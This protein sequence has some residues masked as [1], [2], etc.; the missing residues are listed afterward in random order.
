METYTFLDWDGTLLESDE[1]APEEALGRSARAGAGASDDSR[2]RTQDESNVRFLE[3]I[4]SLSREVSIVTLARR[5]WVEVSARRWLPRT[6]DFLAAHAI[7][8][9]YAVELEAPLDAQMASTGETQALPTLL[10]RRAMEQSLLDARAPRDIVIVSVGD[11]EYEKDA[12]IELAWWRGASESKTILV[13]SHARA[14]LG[15]QL[16]AAAHCLVKARRF[17]GHINLDASSMADHVAWWSFR[18]E[19]EEEEGA[20]QIEDRAH[21]TP[22]PRGLRGFPHLLPREGSS[23]RVGRETA[24]GGGGGDAPRVTARHRATQA[25]PAWLLQGPTSRRS[26]AQIGA[27]THLRIRGR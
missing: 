2:F 6:A 26:C 18:E 17:S 7:P 5:P 14:S 24:E 11:S 25:C 13:S 21:S 19:E 20:P 23:G 3:L 9:Y 16:L 22:P 10:K 27:G 1:L 4:K 15:A 12:A 8:I